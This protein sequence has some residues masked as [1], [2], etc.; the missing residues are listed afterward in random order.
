MLPRRLSEPGPILTYLSELRKSDGA[1]ADSVQERLKVLLQTD[2]GAMFLDLLEKSTTL[3]LVPILGD[4]RALDAK[5]AQGFIAADL[6]RILSDE[7][8]QLVQRATD[9]A[10][11]RR[12]IARG[13]PR[14]S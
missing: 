5:N 11:Q 4:Q 7:T 13:E 10:S 12:R 14:K 9:A 3:R 6:R 8:D 1:L 2:S